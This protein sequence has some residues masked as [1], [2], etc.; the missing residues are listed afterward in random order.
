[1]PPK[2]DGLAPSTKCA[3]ALLLVQAQTKRREITLF[4]RADPRLDFLKADPKLD[5]SPP[6]ATR[7]FHFYSG[8]DGRHALSKGASCFSTNHLRA[9][10]MCHWSVCGQ[11]FD[12]TMKLH[13]TC[14]FVVWPPSL[15]LPF[16]I[17][18]GSLTCSE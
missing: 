3:A 10:L 18:L 11:R 12:S 17:A 9:V 4:K 5:A 8:L 15:S 7:I 2:D 16:L 14:R 13:C 6:L 1:M